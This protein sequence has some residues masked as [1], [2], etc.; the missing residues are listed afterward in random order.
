MAHPQDRSVVPLKD[1]TFGAV[2]REAFGQ[3]GLGHA[4]QAVTNLFKKVLGEINAPADRRQW[5]RTDYEA[6]RTALKENLVGTAQK[7]QALEA[8]NLALKQALASAGTPIPTG[9]SSGADPYPNLGGLYA[10][11]RTWRR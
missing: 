2:R 4:L 6:E 5:N 11:L 10:G 3:A 7:I 9:A 8:E 1:G